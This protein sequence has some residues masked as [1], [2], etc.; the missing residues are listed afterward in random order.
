MGLHVS[1]SGHL[2]SRGKHPQTIQGLPPSQPGVH[3]PFPCFSHPPSRLGC[4]APAM[5]VMGQVTAG[6]PV[7]LGSPTGQHSQPFQ[8]RGLWSVPAGH[9]CFKAVRDVP[10]VFCT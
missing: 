7:H 2:K 4:P 1:A 3:R 9:V 10:N 8:K 5:A 6:M